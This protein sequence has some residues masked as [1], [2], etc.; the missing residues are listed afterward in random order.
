MA[1]ILSFYNNK[2]LHNNSIINPG[3]PA[4]AS[5]L[6]TLLLA[7]FAA[8]LAFASP[9]TAASSTSRG[10][11]SVAQ[12]KQMLEQAPTDRSAQQVLIAYLA[13][14]GE[15][16]SA[17]AS[18]GGASCRTSLS[19]SV[20]NVRQAL[21]AAAAQQDSREIAATPLIVREMLDRAGCAR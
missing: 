11:I 3:A 14:V 1:H 6:P 13:G 9:S 18:M 20:A 15:A 12:V 8:A 2:F 21:G 4:Y 17:V 10:L 7:A 5:S 19:L 16:A